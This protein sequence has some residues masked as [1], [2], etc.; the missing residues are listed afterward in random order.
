MSNESK[1][2]D[3]KCARLICAIPTLIMGDINTEVLPICQFSFDNGA[4]ISK[5]KPF[6]ITCVKISKEKYVHISMKNY[7]QNLSQ[8]I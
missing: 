8:R 2:T 5:V 7:L 6:I 4:V 1:I 3:I